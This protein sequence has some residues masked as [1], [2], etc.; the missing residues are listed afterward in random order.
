MQKLGSSFGDFDK[1][2]VVKVY[3]IIQWV[4]LRF[5]LQTKGLMRNSTY[6]VD[7]FQT[8]ACGG[9]RDTAGFLNRVNSYKVS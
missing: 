7:N 9:R 2:N 4:N 1:L 6:K 3:G 5:P 8:L